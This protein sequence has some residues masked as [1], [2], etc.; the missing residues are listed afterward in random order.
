MGGEGIIKFETDIENEYLIRSTDQGEFYLRILKFGKGGKGGTGHPPGE[1]TDLFEVNRVGPYEGSIKLR[2]KPTTE[3]NIGDEIQI[4]AELTS[5]DGDKECIFWIKI[6]PKNEKE[7]KQVDKEEEYSL[8]RLITVFKEQNVDI[9]DAKTW[10]DYNWTG[11]DVVKVFPSSKEN[12]LIDAV[13]VNVDSFSLSQYLRSNRLSG[14]RLE[15]AKRVYEIGIFLTSIFHYYE[16][17]KNQN[18]WKGLDA[19]DIIA[20]LMKGYSKVM[21]Y[22][23][24]NDQLLKELEAIE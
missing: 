11:E 5:P 2:I 13:A 4:S 6:G 10:S 12:S 22:L 16:V 9:P 8:P 17:K 1:V 18:E 21:L 3:I 23:L 24:L 14:S 20:N 7:E 19:E 15:A